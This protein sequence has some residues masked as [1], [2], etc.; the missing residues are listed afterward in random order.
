VLNSFTSNFKRLRPIAWLLAGLSLVF[1]GDRSGGYLLE[2]LTLKSGLRFSALYR[3][4]ASASILV[5]G[6][7]R[8]VACCHPPSMTSRIGRRTF[9]L[10]HNGMSLELV[11]ILLEDYLE[12]NP[13]PGTVLLE[14]SNA[15]VDSNL[16]GDLRAYFGSSERLR[17][18][19][20]ERDRK[21]LLASQTTHLYRYN[22]EMFLRALYYRSHSDQES[23][24]QYHITPEHILAAERMTPVTFQSRSANLRALRRISRRALELGIE[25]RLVVSPYLPAYRKKISNYETWLHELNQTVG[26]EHSVL[27]FGAA[28]NDNH[29]FADRLHM[30]VEGSR[31][32]IDLLAKAGVFERRLPGRAKSPSLTSR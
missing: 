1:A 24:N 31:R 7:S 21:M 20:R 14:V 3:G 15:I 29:L 19:A 2:R 5:F 26:P 22:S 27:D 16:V 25:L 6:D 32:F 10:A 18:L 4:G 30:T 13:A 8:G 23:A 28:L 17:A 12:R 9:G 11:E